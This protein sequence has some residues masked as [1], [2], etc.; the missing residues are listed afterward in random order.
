MTIA[1]RQFL[2]GAVGAGAAGAVGLALSQSRGHEGGDDARVASPATTLPTAPAK[3][4]L[5]LV[6]LYGGNDGLDTVIPFE[7][8]GYLGA[9]GPL[10]HSDGNVI[11][12]ADG[13]A[14]HPALTGLKGLWD[15]RQLAIVRGVGYPRPNRS[16]FVSMDIWQTGSTDGSTRGWLGPWLDATGSDPLRAI[17]VGTSVPRALKGEKASATSVPVG[18]FA[19]PGTRAL[20]AAFARM[21]D[22][23]GFDAPLAAAVARSG[24]DL[25][26][27]ARTITDVVASQPERDAGAANLEGAP[28]GAG[29]GGYAG[30]LGEQLSLVARL[31][32]AD[33]PTTVY[34]V[35]LG[36]FDTHADEK[37]VHAQ[38]LGE[39]DTSLTRFFADL[40]GDPRRDDVV[41][42]VYSE[43]GRRVASNASGGTD[44]GAAGPVFV[45]GP[46]V[47]GGTFY[48]DEPSLTDLD[49]GDLKFT[50]DFRSVYATV[51]E[52]IVGFDARRSLGGSFPRLDLL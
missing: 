29:R 47:K 50:T 27:T 37:T 31:I 40:D 11:P 30:E 51:L 13:L 32:R 52:E 16:H 36:G 14:L 17:A 34:S 2:T 48:G 44:H 21:H 5:V 33:L 20:K 23:E 24:A 4:T 43:F 39:L 19:M 12:L 26:T 42:V 46:R 6:T 18:P 25:L 41:V 38:L 35:G 45:V 28:D 49:D 8:A 15:A 3:G 10:G 22:P 7:A 9:R 1:R